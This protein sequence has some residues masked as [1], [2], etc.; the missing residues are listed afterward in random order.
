[1]NM[2]PKW[3]RCSLGSSIDKL[4]FCLTIIFLFS[5][6]AVEREDK[7]KITISI[8]PQAYFVQRIAGEFVTVQSIIPANMDPH[9]FEPS[10]RQLMELSDSDMYIKIG[11]PAFAFE[12]SIIEAV[13]RIE[14]NMKIIDMSKQIELLESHVS[15]H[16]HHHEHDT[17]PHIWVSPENIRII[18]ATLYESL[19]ELLPDNKERIQQNYIEFDMELVELQKEINTKLSE[20]DS[21]KFLIYHPFLGYFAKEFSLQQIAI[22]MEG[23]EPTMRHIRDTIEIAKEHE[24][25][26]IFVQEGFSDKSA[27][28]IADE[29]GA[30][31]VSLNPMEYDALS[32]LRNITR[33]LAQ[34]SH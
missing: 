10:Q 15:E 9:I 22:E 26:V 31:I 12:E 3:V 30:V 8:P 7:T 33:A 32:N 6:C 27:R 20:L 28:M 13:A 17:D 2:S 11:H 14:A 29:I 5:S 4:L 25:K 34:N 21:R 18:I 16:T 24:I 1:M 19:S 23:K